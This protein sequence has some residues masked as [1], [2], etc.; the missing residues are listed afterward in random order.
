MHFRRGSQH[1]RRRASRIVWPVEEERDLAGRRRATPQRRGIVVGQT[2]RSDRVSDAYPAWH[3]RRRGQ[4]RMAGF[5]GGGDEDCLF[6]GAAP[7]WPD[8]VIVPVA[9][10]VDR[11]AVGPSR[12]R[13]E[14]PGPVVPVAD[15]FR[16]VDEDGFFRA[17]RIVRTI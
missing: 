4:F 10:I 16:G 11:P 6:L 15:H 17:G 2:D 14:F 12:R 1:G 5:R 8:R 3:A 9:R 13:R 7:C